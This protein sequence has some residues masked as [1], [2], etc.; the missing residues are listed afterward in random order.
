MNEVYEITPTHEKQLNIYFLFFQMRKYT[1]FKKIV[2]G[3]YP[4]RQDY[5]AEISFAQFFYQQNI[6]NEMMFQ[7]LF[8]S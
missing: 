6:W 5:E 3:D 1:S 2:E 8:R 7:S 4:L